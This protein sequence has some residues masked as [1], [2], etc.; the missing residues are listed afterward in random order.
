MS[1]ER[2]TVSV[3]AVQSSLTDAAAGANWREVSGGG[4]VAVGRPSTV[5]V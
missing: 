5:S 2:V 4:A 1:P 3:T